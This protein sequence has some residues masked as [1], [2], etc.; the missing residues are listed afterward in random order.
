MRVA[1]R[2]RS[3]PLLKLIAASACRARPVLPSLRRSS[4]TAPRPPERLNVLPARS[5]EPLRLSMP[6]RSSL[7]PAP[8]TLLI[9][10]SP[11]TLP[12][13]VM[14]TLPLPMRRSITR[15]AEANASVVLELPVPIVRLPITSP[16]VLTRSSAWAAVSVTPLKP[17]RLAVPVATRA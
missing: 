1:L 17:L 16:V 8:T 9:A 10:K 7:L 14:A 5:T 6:R 11:E 4:S 12:R 2:L 3:L 13:P 15:A